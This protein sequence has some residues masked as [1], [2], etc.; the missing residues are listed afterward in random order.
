MYQYFILLW[1]N[2]IPLSG[3]T[4]FL[5]FIHLYG[6][7]GCFHFGTIMNKTAMNVH[8]QVLVWTY[9][10]ISFHLLAIVSNVV[11]NIGIQISIWTHAFSSF[12]CIPRLAALRGNSIFN[13]L[14]S[15]HIA[16]Y[17]AAPFDILMSNAQGSNFSTSSSTLTLFLSFFL[18][19]AIL[20]DVTTYFL[21]SWNHLGFLL[22]FF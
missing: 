1:L 2:N 17:S 6:H 8:G 15:L 9:I 20:I 18:I 12:G 19:V 5:R 4:T 16:F 11:M 7:L 13:F 21:H 10:F 14:K 3:Y 22:Y